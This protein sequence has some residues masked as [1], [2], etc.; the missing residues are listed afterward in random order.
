MRRSRHLLGPRR[1]GVSDSLQPT[2]HLAPYFNLHLGRRLFTQPVCGRIAADWVKENARS[3]WYVQGGEDRGGRRKS[4]GRVR[5]D[6][7]KGGT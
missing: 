4:R 3:S 5:K 2:V 6:Q 1:S 7:Q